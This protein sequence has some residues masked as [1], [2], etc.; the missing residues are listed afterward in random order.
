LTNI[1][2]V[3]LVPVIFFTKMGKAGLQWWCK[4]G[5]FVIYLMIFSAN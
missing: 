4:K 2:S 1:K 5:Q 3:L